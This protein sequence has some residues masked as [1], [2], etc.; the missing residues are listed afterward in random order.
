MWAASICAAS[1]VATSRAARCGI[2]ARPQVLVD[3]R[4]L[5]SA[6][7]Q[8]GDI[9]RERGDVEVASASSRARSRPTASWP[10]AARA[11]SS[12]SPRGRAA[13]SSARRTHRAAPSNGVARSCASAGAPHVVFRFS[14]STP[15]AL[16]GGT[17]RSEPKAMCSPIDIGWTV[18][19]A[20]EAREPTRPRA[21]DCRQPPLSALANS[22]RL[23]SGSSP[24][25]SRNA[26]GICRRRGT[27][28]FCRSASQ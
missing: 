6:P 9:V 25:R 5:C 23:A 2:R 12:R 16:S 18:G 17:L 19:V 22:S 1:A 21:P 15:P 3:E 14:R 20:P 27:P 4:Q 7:T 26:T 8:L 13:R 28:S 24:V 11:S 10:T